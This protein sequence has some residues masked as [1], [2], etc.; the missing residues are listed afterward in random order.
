M[1]IAI[2]YVTS[3]SM[4]VKSDFSDFLDTIVFSLIAQPRHI[5]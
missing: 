5:E 1:S 3:I 4:T 2:N